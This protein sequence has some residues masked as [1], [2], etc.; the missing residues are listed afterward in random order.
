MRSWRLL[1]VALLLAAPVVAAQE[2]AGNHS[3]PSVPGAPAGNNASAPSPST[4]NSGTPVGPTESVES[5]PGVIYG[6]LVL[7]GVLAFV[8]VVGYLSARYRSRGPRP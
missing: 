4:G 5:A 7:V 3:F 1:A 8:G 6:L 2:G